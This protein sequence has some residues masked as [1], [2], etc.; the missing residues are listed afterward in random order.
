MNS[1]INSVS[2]ARVRIQLLWWILLVIVLLAIPAFSNNYVL[3]MINITLINIVAITGLNLLTG[4]TGLV[5]MG[6]AAFLG[7]GGFTAGIIS[8][9]L[10]F[11]FWIAIIIG[12]F[13][14]MVVGILIGIP[15]LRLKGLYLL[16]AT[17]ALHFIIAFALLYYQTKTSSLSGIRFPR[18]EI[19]GFIFDTQIKSY[20]FLLAVTVLVIIFVR[21]I[22]RTAL[23]RSF[24][25][26]H[27]NEAAAKAMGVN[28]TLTKLVAFAISSFLIGIAGGL[29]GFS[30]RNL[31]AEMF[32]L[33]LTVDHLVALFIGGQAT[34]TGPVLGAAFIILFP[35]FIGFLA[36]V[37]KDTVP[38]L[39]EVLGKYSFEIRT[40]IYGL[41]I[42]LVLIFKP[43]GLVGVLSDLFKS[44]RRLGSKNTLLKE[45][46]KKHEFSKHVEN[47]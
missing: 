29:M 6:N 34:L 43:T 47:G 4:Y 12:G 40:F 20:Y 39:A 3:S 11:P 45:E 41:C 33:N 17:L 13:F 42:V 38:F 7:I 36:D 2:V 37:T 9:Q 21:N 18:M 22:L 28:I 32:N 15:S 24:L 1:Y 26:V 35:D 10:G 5:S 31:T 8:V 46:A 16:L 14:A 44:L 25:A 30:T 23:G 19:A 27:N